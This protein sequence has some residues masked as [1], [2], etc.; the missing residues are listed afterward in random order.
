MIVITPVIESHGKCGF[1]A[2]SKEF[3]GTVVES[4][5]EEGALEEL[6]TSL[7]VLFSYTFK[8]DINLI[9][10]KVITETESKKV[11]TKVELLQV[12]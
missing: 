12:A 9:S 11:S 5:T 7:K 6:I 4:D 3:K 2:W 8:W 10:A 1:I